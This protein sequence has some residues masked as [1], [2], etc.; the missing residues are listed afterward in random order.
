MYLN[1]RGIRSTAR[2]NQVLLTFM[3]MSLLAKAHFLTVKAPTH[4]KKPAKSA[5]R[6]NM[7]TTLVRPCRNSLEAC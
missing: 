1:L 5:P 3:F 6:L 2:A 4:G 7:V